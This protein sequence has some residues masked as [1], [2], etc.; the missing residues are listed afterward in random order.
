ML[1]HIDSEG[2]FS[3]TCPHCP[4]EPQQAH[5]SHEQVQVSELDDKHVLLPPCSCGSRTGIN[6]AF[7]E[8]DLLPPIT[9]YGMLPT[10]PPRQGIIKVEI[11]GA[12]NFTRITEHYERVMING[13][14]MFVHVIDSVEQHP[15]LK[16]HLDMARQ[17][18]S[19]GKL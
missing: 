10:Q 5:I 14:E 13:E 8:K 7:S 17:L 4:S 1:H 19:I 6:V 3:W 11:P 18:K 15:A 16:H 12:S 2:T 9:T